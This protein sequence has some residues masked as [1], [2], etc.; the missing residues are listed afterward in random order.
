[1]ILHPVPIDLHVTEHRSLV[2]QILQHMALDTQEACRDVRCHNE[3]VTL[4]QLAGVCMSR[5]GHRPVGLVLL[6][7][8]DAADYIFRA[9]QKLNDLVC[10]PAEVVIKKEEIR[11][12]WRVQKLRHHLAAGLCDEWVTASL[13]PAP[14][15]PGLLAGCVCSQG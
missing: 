8:V 3:P 7:G 1:M 2:I 15:E 10:R 5:Q 6:L 9:V 14:G 13:S 11:S 4:N 12:L